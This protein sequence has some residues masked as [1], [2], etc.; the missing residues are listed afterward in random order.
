MNPYVFALIAAAASFAGGWFLCSRTQA[1]RAADAHRIV[2]T[3]Q[4]AAN[5][6]LEAARNE[7]HAGIALAEAKAAGANADLSLKVL[8][9]RIESLDVNQ[10][11]MLNAFLNSGLMNLHVRQGKNTMTGQPDPEK[12][13]PRL[14]VDQAKPLDA[15]LR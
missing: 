12:M 8:I 13:P 10:A 1:N 15:T 3:M 7:S 11:S 5:V 4:Q 9:E 2:A 14:E 6:L